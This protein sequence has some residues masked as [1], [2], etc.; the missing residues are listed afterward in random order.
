MRALISRAAAV[1]LV[2]CAVAPLASQPAPSPQGGSPAERR[3]VAALAAVEARP[4]AA[5]PRV[6]L[7]WALTK[8]AREINDP[9]YYDRAAEAAAKALELEPGNWDARKAQVWVLLGRHEF[10][11][12]HEE[13]LKLN[14]LMKDDVMVYGFLA[15]ANAELGNY[16]QAEEAVQWMLDMRP[17]HL[18][19]LTRAA[20][21]REV[22][23]DVDGAIEAYATAASRLSPVETEDR[24]WILSQIGHLLLSIGK[25]SEAATALQQALD[26]FPGYHYAVGTLAKVRL[27]QQ[28]PLEAV[29]LYKQLYA[30]APHPENLYLLAEALES[31][32]SPEAARAFADFERRALAESTQRDNANRELVLYYLDRA[33]KPAEGLR[34]AA[35]ERAHRQ[36]VFTLDAH[37]WALSAVGR[38]GEARREIDR[39]LA[40]GIRDAAM[41]YHAGVIASRQG[42]REAA[43]TRL[44]ASL[45]VN[46]R[47]AVADR[48]RAELAR[49][50][51]AS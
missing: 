43:R 37:A 32:R 14:T 11:R 15:D 1:G 38:H 34:I 29:A 42:D 47:S 10:A 8:R 50:S 25:E 39:A 20:Y 23:G 9:T 18:S 22:F 26:A 16:Q 49:V 19:G 21:L 45:A 44:E 27:A 24:A 31:A 51:R 12:A 17:A 6:D 46:P 5:Q 13:A 40:V 41:L 4:A 36:D 28:K 35:L 7:A 3:I 2:A 33:K 48:V 30:A